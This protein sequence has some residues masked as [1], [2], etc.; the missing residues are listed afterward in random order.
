MVFEFAFAKFL[1]LPLIAFG[2]M[3]TLLLFLA[4]ATMGFMINR[5][6]AKIPVRVHFTMAIISLCVGL[7][8]GLIA[9]LAFLGL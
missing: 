4:T 1:G 2:G 9:M 6:L 5:G 7:M 3:F 8:H